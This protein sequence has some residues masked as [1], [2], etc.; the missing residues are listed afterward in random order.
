MRLYMHSLAED[1]WV[2][3][4]QTMQPRSSMPW[5]NLHA[6]TERDL[7]AISQFIRYLWPGETP[8]PAYLV[9]DQEPLQPY[10]QFPQP[11]H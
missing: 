2:T 5:F 3:V 11:P 1:Q 10:L 9:P 4:A 7:R 8:A 6:M